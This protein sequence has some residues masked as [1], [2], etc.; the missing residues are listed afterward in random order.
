MASTQFKTMA[1]LQSQG[2]TVLGE[3][4][5]FGSIKLG[6]AIFKEKRLQ[7]TFMGPV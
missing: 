6:N 7:V 4:R 3:I 2:L 5:G 1:R